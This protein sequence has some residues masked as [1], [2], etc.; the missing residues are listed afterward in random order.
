M[1]EWI[2]LRPVLEVEAEVEEWI[3]AAES[4]G[5]DLSRREVLDHFHAR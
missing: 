4:P 3:R 5:S 2:D 1:N